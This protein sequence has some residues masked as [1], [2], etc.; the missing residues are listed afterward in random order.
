M[1]ISCLGVKL[2]HISL[3]LL[4][5]GCAVFPE[6]SEESSVSGAS[7]SVSIPAGEELAL[8]GEGGLSA[9]SPDRLSFPL[10]PLGVIGEVEPVYLESFSEP[11]F[12]R[13]DTGAATSSIDARDIKAFERDGKRW[14]SFYVE[15][16]DTGER[17]HFE[18]PVKRRLRIKRAL[19]DERRFSVELA[20]RLGKEVVKGEFTLSDRE[21]FEYP[22]LLGRNILSGLAVV[23]VSR[24]NT[25]K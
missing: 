17:S 11:F 14:V 13:V 5:S 3:L 1:R 23:D 9:E 4:L 25:L 10:Y 19:E 21:E 16:P 7:A 15:H 8:I 12:A 2:S 18:C 22:V 20:V 6:S 24:S